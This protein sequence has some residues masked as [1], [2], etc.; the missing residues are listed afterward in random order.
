MSDSS[1]IK[2]I[3]L[4][5]V[6]LSPSKKFQKELN[7]SDIWEDE[8]TLCSEH[9]GSLD[10]NVNSLYDNGNN[11]NVALTSDEKIVHVIKGGRG[12][13]PGSDS[14]RKIGVLINL[15]STH[16]KI[17][18]MHNKTHKSYNTEKCNILRN[19][20]YKSAHS[21]KRSPIDGAH[22]SEEVGFPL[23]SN[24]LILENSKITRSLER[25]SPTGNS[26]ENFLSNPTLGLE[27]D[28]DIVSV[29]R[30]VSKLVRP[31]AL[32][33]S[34]DMLQKRIFAGIRKD[35]GSTDGEDSSS[36]SVK[37]QIVQDHVR[38]ILEG[39][40]LGSQSENTDSTTTVLDMKREPIQGC[41]DQKSTNLNNIMKPNF[42]VG[43]AI[44]PRIATEQKLCL[45][46]YKKPEILNDQQQDSLNSIISAEST[47][48]PESSEHFTSPS[49]ISVSSFASSK[50]LEWDSSADVGYGN[51][52]E[53]QLYL[54]SSLSTLERIAIENY[55]SVLRT[56]PEGKGTSQLKVK[57]NK[58]FG[59]IKE[60]SNVSKTK[61]VQLFQKPSSVKNVSLLNSKRSNKHIQYGAP[62]E[63]RLTTSSDEE[64]LNINRN[65]QTLSANISKRYLLN[66]KSKNSRYFNDNQNNNSPSK[67]FPSR[68]KTRS[69]SNIPCTLD[70][71]DACHD[72]ELTVSNK[73][74]SISCHSNMSAASSSNISTNS[75]TLVN[76]NLSLPVV[77]QIKND[78]SVTLKGNF[79]EK[80]PNGEK[81]LFES[82][83]C[84]KSTSR[85]GE[86]NES[87]E[88][89]ISQFVGANLSNNDNERIS[90]FA[91]QESNLRLYNPDWTDKENNSAIILQDLAMKLK[92]HMN[93]LIESGAVKKSDDYNTLQGYVE[94][95]SQPVTSKEDIKLKQSI[96]DII[97]KLFGNFGE[98]VYPT[99]LDSEESYQSLSSTINARKLAIDPE[100]CCDEKIPEDLKLKKEEYSSSDS[101]IGYVPYKPATVSKTYYIA[102]FGDWSPNGEK[103]EVSHN[104]DLKSHGNIV[105]YGEGSL[106]KQNHQLSSDKDEEKEYLERPFKGSEKVLL[107][108]S[109]SNKAIYQDYHG[110]YHVA[111]QPPGYS[112]NEMDSQH[113]DSTSENEA[114]KN[115]NCPPNEANFNLQGMT[116]TGSE[117]AYETIRERHRNVG[118]TLASSFEF[119]STSPRDARILGYISGHST[120][121]S[122]NTENSHKVDRITSD[123]N[124][125][126]LIVDS[127]VGS[128]KSS[129]RGNENSS[130]LSSSDK[131]KLIRKSN[132]RSTRRNATPRKRRI[133][134]H[135]ESDAGSSSCSVIQVPRQKYVQRIRKYIHT[136]EKL[137]RN[138][139]PSSESLAAYESNPS[140]D[141][142]SK[143]FLGKGKMKNFSSESVTTNCESSIS[144]RF[145]SSEFVDSPHSSRSVEDTFIEHRSSS[146]QEDKSQEIPSL[147]IHLNNQ[148]SSKSRGKR[149]PEDKGFQDSNRNILVEDFGHISDFR[150]LMASKD[151]EGEMRPYRYLLKDKQ[152]REVVSNTY[153]DDF[154]DRGK[155]IGRLQEKQVSPTSSEAEL[156]DFNMAVGQHNKEASNSSD[157]FSNNINKIILETHSQPP[158]VSSEDRP[159]KLVDEKMSKTKETKD[160]GQTFPSDSFYDLLANK[161]QVSVSIQTGESLLVMN[162]SDE[163]QSNLKSVNPIN[164]IEASASPSPLPPP[165][166]SSSSPP[167]TPISRHFS[168]LKETNERIKENAKKIE[169]ARKAYNEIALKGNLSSKLLHSKSS[170]TESL[171]TNLQKKFQTESIISEKNNLFSSLSA[172]RDLSTEQKNENRDIGKMSDHFVS[173]N[174]CNQNLFSSKPLE[175]QN[176]R[177]IK[178]SDITVSENKKSMKFTVTIDNPCKKP[179]KNKSLIEEL[180][181]LNKENEIM[182][183]QDALSLA[184]PLYVKEAERRRQKICRKQAL[185]R[186]VQSHNQEVMSELPDN[187]KTPSVLQKFLFKSEESPVFSYKAMRKQNQRL[188]QLLPE[189]KEPVV[190]KKKEGM[191]KTNRLMAKFYSQ[192]LRRKVISGKVSHS[193]KEIVTPAR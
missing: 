98:H 97:V 180:I 65:A 102:E 122:K 7:E 79:P 118:E 18:K 71:N 67:N 137:E 172:E 113:S 159:S 189:A 1:S 75:S 89:A 121:K 175:N 80:Q 178:E 130:T 91:N 81:L 47:Y 32:G 73:E 3:R 182:S 15:K 78:F 125:K 138:L 92:Y 6:Y 124:S 128:F 143:R 29:N 106:E 190:T 28:E 153:D 11:S 31:P 115:Q 20:M 42:I 161:R 74:G 36:E 13:T 84:V 56:E 24:I 171:K 191:F 10:S 135:H 93:T 23:P 87:K 96:A 54:A 51:K 101:N 117:S 37:H 165:F 77:T 110:T 176:L 141:S 33:Q 58:K 38:T 2:S 49:G 107:P 170:S 149:L 160:F 66:T 116:S 123:G 152:N 61:E 26:N 43:G 63:Q 9:R 139:M 48:H 114:T 17:S 70:I 184:R 90:S 179:S 193:H 59:N 46:E 119:Y 120:E 34:E 19:K 30:P 126:S 108:S 52:L 53:N 45:L 183:L 39:C 16:T 148:T 185:R 140:F 166:S 156:K 146:N 157:T 145:V 27:D 100:Q 62:I 55:A 22:G 14:P 64:V 167:S 82:A 134:T 21:S 136:L 151:V 164:E 88:K 169:A 162:G 99:T 86:E 103:K 95:V 94:F 174:T 131:G 72:V 129:E 85:K 35:L 154:V 57:G 188:Y 150:K 181:D 76:S 144:N 50:K 105:E 112:S 186:Y 177:T 5:E 111:H 60:K 69:L 155:N 133:N 132:K 158:F 41:E 12:E 83:F 44:S 187:I 142:S 192:K 68:G 104:L 163:V 25:K 109:S 147:K 8:S 127:E 168:A 4:P 173:S 40:S